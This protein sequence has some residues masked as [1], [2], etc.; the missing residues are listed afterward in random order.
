MSTIAPYGSWP[1]TITAASVSASSVRYNEPRFADGKL[2]WLESRPTEKGRNAVVT[3]TPNNEPQDVLPAPWSAQSKVHEYGGGA[4]TVWQDTL[5]FVN[6]GDQQIYAMSL[7]DKNPIALTAQPAMRFADLTIDAHRHRLLAVAEDHGTGQGE[8]ENSI[9]SISL[10]ASGA[11]PDY[12]ARGHDFYTAPRLSPCG[13]WLAYLSWNHPNMPW[14]S[15]QLW[16]CALDQQGSPGDPALIAGTTEESVFQ[17]SWSPR[18]HLFW[19]S[20]K[21]NW[22]NL[23]RLSAD[24]LQQPEKAAQQSSIC[25]MDAEFGLPQWAFSMST[26]G[27][28]GEDTLFVTYNQNGLWQAARLQYSA[29]DDWQLT[30]LSNDFC[31]YSGITCESGKAAFI[32]ASG[33]QPSAVYIYQDESVKR[34]APGQLNSPPIAEISQAQALTYTTDGATTHA[35]FYPP[36][37]RQYT[38]PALSQPPVIA[39]CHGGPT[40]ATDASFNYKIQFWTN[41][42]FAVLDVNYRGSTGYGRAYRHALWRN[43]GLSDVADLVAGVEY[44]SEKGWVNPKQRIV[45]GSSAGGYTVLAALTDSDT[46]NAGVS[47]Y[48]IGD[49]ETLVADTHKFESQYL[50]RLVGPYPQEKDEYYRRSPIHKVDQIQCPVLVFQG[51]QDKVVPPEQ[52]QSIVDAVNHQGLPVAYVTYPDEAHGFRQAKAIE[53][54]LQAEL[55]FYQQIFGLSGTEATR[56]APIE[57]LNEEAI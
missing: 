18:G 38:A 32:A 55:Y 56:P 41:R 28:L 42:G 15:S 40:G 9:V 43:W 3:D 49:L 25:P 6:G 33:T 23:Y 57:I 11:A 1:S 4:Y 36:R 17:P 8:P 51:L 5:Y 19:V 20:D 52:A 53:H 30:P 35:F 13:N 31:T 10:S 26:Y 37:N 54:Q 14:D 46:F 22:W 44:L 48:G 34:C 2:F 21:S 50:E 27:F 16:L 29:E 12:I 39:L 45:R 24:L 7:Q 47:L